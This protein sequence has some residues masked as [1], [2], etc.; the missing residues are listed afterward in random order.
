MSKEVSL[1]QKVLAKTDTAISRMFSAP[2]SITGD[3]KGKRIE[4]HTRPGKIIGIEHP[5]GFV[6]IGPK[7]TVILEFDVDGKIVRRRRLHQVDKG[8][9]VFS[10]SELENYRKGLPVASGGMQ[11]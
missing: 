9:R 1:G 8:D 5:D 7:N 6:S 11:N 3:P 2:V 4:W 10:D